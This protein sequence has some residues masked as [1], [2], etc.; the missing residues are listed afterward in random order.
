MTDV[1]AGLP[2]EGTG[3][4]IARGGLILFYATAGVFHLLVTDAMVRIVPAWVPYP[5]A[6]VI[7]TG[8]CEL[9]GAAGLVTIRWRRAAG[10]ALALYAVCVF[11]ANIK[12]MIV[13]LHTGHGLSIWYHGPR[14]LLQPVIVWWS[15][16][17]SGA[18]RGQRARAAQHPTAAA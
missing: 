7:A 16:W 5:H 15:L 6:V 12:H 18:V 11:P 13:D 3:R 8:L 17:A 9:A 2:G 1:P 14:M 10:I 4:R